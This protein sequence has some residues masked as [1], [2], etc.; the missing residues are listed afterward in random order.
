ME[1]TRRNYEPSYKLEI[2]KMIKEQGLS[3]A[4]VCRDQTIGESA[5]RLFNQH[6]IQ[7]QHAAGR[8]KLLQRGDS[9]R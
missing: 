4:Q 1:T 3:L 8:Y 5:V 2:V 9:R 7:W 6:K